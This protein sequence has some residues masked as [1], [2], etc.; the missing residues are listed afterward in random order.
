[1]FIF[2]GQLQ[3]GSPRR[4]YS[5]DATGGARGNRLFSAKKE[6]IEKIADKKVLSEAR[7]AI[8]KE[9]SRKTL[10]DLAAQGGITNGEEIRAQFKSS[11]REATGEKIRNDF[12]GDAW[13]PRPFFI[14]APRDSAYPKIRLDFDLDKKTVKLRSPRMGGV[15]CEENIENLASVL[16]FANE[17]LLN[18][19]KIDGMLLSSDPMH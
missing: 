19:K 12:Y 16:V 9:T 11:L 3:A 18:Y 15:L 7:L 2:I 17:F 5:T 13:G 8:I 10:E 1:M 4:F 14:W 6:I